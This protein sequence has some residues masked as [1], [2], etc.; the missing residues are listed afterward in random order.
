MAQSATTINLGEIKVT[1]LFCFDQIKYKIV[2][3]QTGKAPQYLR[4]DGTFAH[5]DASE[6]SMIGTEVSLKVAAIFKGKTEQSQE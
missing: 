6:D 4:T 5:I 2:D 1:P 3:E